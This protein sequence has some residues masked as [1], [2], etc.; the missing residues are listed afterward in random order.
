MEGERVR[1]PAAAAPAGASPRALG[2]PAPHLQAQPGAGSLSR[3]LHL[4]QLPEPPTVP[5]RAAVPAER[6]LASHP[7]R[8][9]RARLGPGRRALTSGA[10]VAEDGARRRAR[11]GGAEPPRFQGA[12]GNAREHD[13]HPPGASEQ[14]PLC[15][16]SVPLPGRPES[17]GCGT[18]EGEETGWGRYPATAWSLG[19]GSS[20]SGVPGR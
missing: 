12:R 17:R 13:S 2:E 6:R 9:G 20:P 5:P 16:R 19:G 10:G 14:R 11:P 7:A 18:E 1:V 8:S 15:S 3:P 4:R